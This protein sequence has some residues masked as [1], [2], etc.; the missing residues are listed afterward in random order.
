MASQR[1]EILVHGGTCRE[2]AR[3]VANLSTRVQN[4]LFPIVDPNEDFIFDEPRTAKISL[5]QQ[6]EILRW[7]EY[8]YT[9]EPHRISKTVALPP[10]WIPLSGAVV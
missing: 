10:E 6:L 1:D 2:E 5:Y 3:L 9:I 8:N 4:T 7:L